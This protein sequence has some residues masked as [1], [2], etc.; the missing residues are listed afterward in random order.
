M[1]SLR[2]QKKLLQRSVKTG[3]GILMK[4]LNFITFFKKRKII[5]KQLQK[6]SKIVQGES[7]KILAE[8]EKLQDED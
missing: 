4:R 1:L 6:E 8:F 7:M 5:S 2:R 3:T